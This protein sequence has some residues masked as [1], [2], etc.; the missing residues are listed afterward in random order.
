[1]NLDVTSYTNGARETHN[2]PGRALPFTVWDFY[3][4]KKVKVLLLVCSAVIV[5]LY[6]YIRLLFLFC[7]EM[8]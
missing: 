7:D 3:E 6:F 2:P 5:L 1:M 8:F 4:V